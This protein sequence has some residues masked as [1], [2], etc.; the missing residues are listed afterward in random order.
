[1]TTSRY[2][3]EDQYAITYSITLTVKPGVTPTGGSTISTKTYI[4]SQ[5]TNQVSVESRVTSVGTAAGG[6]TFVT[7][8]LRPSAISTIQPQTTDYVYSYY[9]RNCRNPTATGKAYYGPNS[10]SGDSGGSGNSGSSGGGD[11]LDRWGVCSAL[12]GCTTL[13]VWIIV[14][15]T[16]LPS[17]FLLGFV[18]NYIWFRRLMIGKTALRFGTVCWVLLSLWILCFTRKQPARSPED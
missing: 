8:Y 14:V 12:T 2:G 17:I 4:P 9:V 1:M 15:A 5:V 13:K 7:A 10:G 3:S 18:E 11:D 6:Y 16:I